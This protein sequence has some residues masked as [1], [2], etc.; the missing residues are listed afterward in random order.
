[1]TR[2]RPATQSP[3]FDQ[4]LQPERTDLAWRRTVL[5]LMV[6]S[7]IS[8]RLLPA[9]LGP[10][11]FM[12]PLGGVLGAGW[13]LM[14]TYRRAREVQRVLL[15]GSG[16]LPDGRLMLGLATIVLSAACLGVLYVLLL[17]Q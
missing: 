13:L 12:V 1:M 10:W 16:A 7:L 8:A 11:A 4:G 2:P 9:V 5:A 15:G 3:R 14:G 17:R 6:G